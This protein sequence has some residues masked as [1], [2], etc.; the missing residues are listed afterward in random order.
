MAKKRRQQ[1]ARS[2]SS[3]RITKKRIITYGILAAVIS[4]I[5]FAG[6]RSMIPSNGVAPVFGMANNHFIKAE[7]SPNSGYS[8]VTMSSGSTKGMKNTGG[9][10]ATFD[11]AYVFN[12]GGLQSIHIVNE[13]YQTHSKHNFNID[14]LNIHSK[15]LTYPE[16]QT[17]TFVADKAGTFDYYCTIHPEMKGQITVQ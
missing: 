1:N 7:Y 13:D 3:P 6:Y 5:G 14:E 10:G 9:G 4:A 12:K 2:I 17:I 15:D 11:P 8:W 16:T